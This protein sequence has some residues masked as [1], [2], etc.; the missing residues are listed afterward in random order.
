MKNSFPLKRTASERREG[1]T[2]IYARACPKCGA[3]AW[4][5]CVSQ[6][7]MRSGSHHVA[8]SVI[9]KKS[10]PLPDLSGWWKAQLKRKAVA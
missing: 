5:Y 7:G 10:D 1:N 9:P 3:P 2:S 6:A 4:C 8:R